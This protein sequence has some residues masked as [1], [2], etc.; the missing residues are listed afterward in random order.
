[1][2]EK[3]DLTYQNKIVKWSCVSDYQ[4]RPQADLC[5]RLATKS[6]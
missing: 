4:N 5:A 3:I 1:L 2:T 6:S